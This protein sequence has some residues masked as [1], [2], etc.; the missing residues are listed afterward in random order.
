MKRRVMRGA[1]LLLLIFSACLLLSWPISGAAE[2][3]AQEETTQGVD[4]LPLEGLQQSA[5]EGSWPLDVRGVMRSFI[6]GG[7]VTDHEELFDWLKSRM[8]EAVRSSLPSLAVLLAP[9]LL[10]ALCRQMTGEAL[11]S[12]AEIVCSLAEAGMLA[13]I[14]SERMAAARQVTQQLAGLIERFYPLAA[15]VLSAG[16]RTHAASLMRPSG[17][18]AVSICEGVMTCAAFAL[19]ACMAALT[20]AGVLS[21]RLKTEGL[22]RLCRRAACWILGC[23]A[24]LFLGVMKADALLEGGR[25][26]LTLRA[27]EYAVDKLLPVIGGD[28]A[29][30]LG[31]VAA[32]TA[33]MRSAVGVTGTAVLLGLCLEPLIALLSDILCCRLAAALSDTVGEGAASRCLNGFAE[34][35]QILFLT[36]VACA[37]LFLILTSVM[38]KGA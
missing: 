31:T 28:V 13:G 11:N 10:G 3:G 21:A 6:S 38:L 23:A 4:E 33:L 27:A 32:G 9:A 24:T 8:A 26:A 12:S 22:F 19:S 5:D 29:D 14:F 30:T 35:M 7:R 15:F 2:D 37:A 36:Q 25:D 17:A 34:A 16:G 18:L 1:A 20:A